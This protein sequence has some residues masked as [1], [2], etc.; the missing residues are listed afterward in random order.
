M[1]VHNFAF[2]GATAEEDLLSQFSHFKESSR[3]LTLGGENSVYCKALPVRRSDRLWN[4][5]TYSPLLGYQRLR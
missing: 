5:R 1:R 2:P 3:D 4:L